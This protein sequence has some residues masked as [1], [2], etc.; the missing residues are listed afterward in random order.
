MNCQQPS[1]F[2]KFRKGDEQIFQQLYYKYFDALFLFGSKYISNSAI[3]EDIV[4]DSF[5]KS[6][7]KRKSFFHESPFKAF[8]YTS[9]K[10]A[11]FNHLEHE[12]VKTKYE[13]IVIIESESFFNNNIIE[14]EVNKHIRECVNKLPTAAREIYLLSLEGVKNS[15]IAEDLQI[16]VNTVKTQKQRAGNFLR[17]KLKK[18]F[19][20]M[21]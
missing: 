17:S 3:V 13:D 20:V 5:M 8:L 9:V 4:Q 10:N 12:K 7:T 19:A 14:E 11:C 2:E 18:V 15:E 1:L 6:W 21:F 16:S